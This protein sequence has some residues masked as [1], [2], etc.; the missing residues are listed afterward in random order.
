MATWLESTDPIIHTLGGTNLVLTANSVGLTDGIS[1]PF[2]VTQTADQLEFTSYPFFGQTNQ[3]VQQIVV[4]ALLPDL[5]VDA[6]FNG[7]ITLAVN[8]GPGGISGTLVKAAINGVATF[9]NIIFN[10][11]GTYTLS[12]T[13]PVYMTPVVS[14]DI[15]IVPFF[16]GF[17]TCP[18]AG[19]QSVLISGNAWACDIEYA[20]VSGLG[21]SGPT[22]AWYL[23]PSINFSTLSN[24]VMIF[25]SW[26]SGTDSNHPRLEVYYSTN[27]T[28]GNPNL[29]T[30]TPL[31][32]NL[33]AENSS[34]WVH[35]GT[36]DLSAITTTA[37]IAFKYTSSGTTAGAATEWRIDNVAITE[38]GCQ[39]PLTQASG[40]LFQ[41]I[42]AAQMT[43]SWTGG[44]GTGRIVLASTSPI[45]DVPVDGTDYVAN[46]SFGTVGT[47]LGSSFVVYKG[48]SNTVT[49]TN[50]NPNTTYHFA[51][52]EYN[53]NN[54]S[55]TFNTV[56]PATG[57]QM[58][59]DPNA[60]DII[61]NPVFVYPVDIAYGTYQAPELTMTPGNSLAVFGL[62][63][64]DGGP[65]ASS[66]LLT[67]TLAGLTFSTNGTAAIRAAALYR[68]GVFIKKASVNGS[69]NDITFDLTAS[70]LEV[71]DMDTAH[72]QLFVTF[73]AGDF[74]IDNEQLVFTVTSAT[75]DPG[76]TLFIT[77]DAGGATSINTGGNENTIR[78]IATA[79]RFEQVPSFSFPSNEEF[80]IEVEA[81]DV[82]LSRDRDKNLRIFRLNGNGTISSASGLTKPTADSTALWTDL[83]YD[84]EES[85]VRFRVTDDGSPALNAT[86]QFLT[87]KPRI[88]I[89]TFTGATGSDVTYPPDKQPIDGSISV[90]SRGAGIIAVN[91][92][93]AFSARSWPLTGSGVDLSGSYYEFTV[94]ANPGYSFNI[95][96]IEFDHRRSDTGPVDWQIRNST[97]GYTGNIGG[98][99]AG[100][101]TWNRN[102]NVTISLTGQSTVTFRIYAFNATQG[103]GNWALDN[104]EIFGNIYDS[105]APS[106]T[107]TYPQ[108]DSIAVKGFDVIVNADE[109]ATVYYVVQLPAVPPPTLNQVIAGLNGN[110]SPAT[111]KRREIACATAATNVRERIN[112]LVSQTLYNVYYVLYDSTNYSSPMLQAAVPTADLTT[113]LVAETLTVPGGVRSNS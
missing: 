83:I 101:A 99:I 111:P 98:P 91:R 90:I 62:T 66:D 59:V 63:I 18:A 71:D 22:E 21:G 93:N 96:S 45:T 58:T 77:P 7:N 41:N 100:S 107:A 95:S 23:S 109:P 79:L 1:D 13:G 97:D 102:E 112:G 54:T 51:V 11:N 108:Y 30:W 19:W 92:A 104:I 57:S 64:R 52:F 48:N 32:F 10:T 34:A 67:T 50:L 68:A 3:V 14:G 110:G 46:A 29:A 106:F 78:V 88:T 37:R 56:N 28:S 86:T 65:A 20:S 31:T 94:S 82:L 39:A 26:T 24:Q 42:Q 69:T 76:G 84:T 36:I 38:N 49:V 74:I 40:L 70:P 12:A 60:S 72:F 103:N 5:S 55:P 8:S 53:C 73:M 43:L 80:T 33:P 44:N 35:S 87:A 113:D 27:Y 16:Q 2:D 15:E 85:N 81:R 89:Y 105:Q 25:D 75:A 4:S 17:L 9:D 47:E 6:T 61:V